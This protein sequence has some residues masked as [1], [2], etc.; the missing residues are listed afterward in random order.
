MAATTTDRFTPSRVSKY[1]YL[2]VAAN[3]VIRGGTMVETD[4]TSGFAAEGSGGA[5]KTL[6][7]KCVEPV[8]NTGGADGA[9]FVLVE[10]AYEHTEHQYLNDGTNP[11]VQG[12]VGADCFCLDN[13]TVTALGTDHSV[14][15]LVCEV[16]SEG[17]WIRFKR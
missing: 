14:A 12:D 7:G 10:G 8:D 9:R 5:N 1:E 15:A 4:D 13:Q 6:W 16:D 2:K 17:V 11:V 3:A